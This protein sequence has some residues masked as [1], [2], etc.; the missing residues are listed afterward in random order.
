MK[1]GKALPAVMDRS[2]LRP[3]RLSGAS[4]ADV[5]YGSDCAVSGGA[6][7]ASI[8]G[9]V[10]GRFDLTVPMM[11]RSVMN[12]LACGKAVCRSLRTDIVFPADMDEAQLRQIMSETAQFCAENG[13]TVAGGHTCVSHGV[14]LPVIT[15]TGIGNTAEHEQGAADQ[16]HSPGEEAVREG[17]LILMAGETG[18]GGTTVLLRAFR[19]ELAGRFPQ[20]MLADA[21]EFEK[22]SL[23]TEAAFTAWK[24]GAL[25]VHD[26]SSGGI[27]AALW[28]MSEYLQTGFEAGLRDILLRQETVEICEY[29][30]L[31]PYQLYG[32]GSLLIAADTDAAAQRII[33]DLGKAGIPAAVIGRTVKGA[34]RVLVNGEDRQYLEK[35]QQD[36]LAKLA[37]AEFE[38]R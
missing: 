14:L 4:G 2:I 21:G 24:D 1:S 8:C 35:P 34:G 12:G 27:L 16:E 6:V 3:L 33:R 5:R 7:T 22:R 32:Q 37:D 36:M 17:T 29:L 38:R 10:G 28:E 13:I 18:L 20:T 19:D 31:N 11:I 23:V 15:F 9:T 30:G 26:V 25:A